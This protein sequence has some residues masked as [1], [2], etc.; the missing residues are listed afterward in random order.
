LSFSPSA[1]AQQ[2]PRAVD[3][4]IMQETLVGTNATEPIVIAADYMAA[5]SETGLNVSLG[6]GNVVVSQGGTAIRAGNAVAWIDR[7]TT[8]SGTVTN[9]VVY[10]EKPIDFEGGGKNGKAYYG[11]IRLATTSGVK[12]NVQ[13]SKLVNS[14]QSNDPIY[15][16]AKANLPADFFM[17]GHGPVNAGARQMPSPPPGAPDPGV[18]RVAASQ[19]PDAAPQPVFPGNVPPANPPVYTSPT[20]PPAVPYQI[21]PA[22]NDPRVSPVPAGPP[23]NS[24]G[25]PILPP[26]PPT[27]G[28]EQ[29]AGTA[30]QMS[31]RPRYSGEMKV[32]YKPLGDGWTAVIVTGGVTMFIT[33]TGDKPGFI[34]IEADRL[35]LWTL[36]NG[37]QLFS[38]M[39]SPGGDMNNAYEIYMSGHVDIRTKSKIETET[40]RADEVYYDLRREVAVARRADLEIQSPKLVYPL[41]MQASEIVKPNAKQYNMDKSKTFASLLPSDP[42]LYFVIENTEV[43]EREYYKR[44]LYGLLP[45]YDKDGQPKIAVDH[46]ITG[47]NMTIWMEGVPFFY[48]P[49]YKGRVEE[50]LGPLQNIS[51]GYNTIFGF[52]LYTTWDMLSLLDLDRVDGLRWRLNIDEQTLRGP[53]LGMELDFNRDKLFD[54]NAKIASSFKIYGIYDTGLDVLGGNR[55]QEIFYPLYPNNP[56]PIVHPI[57]RGW[58]FGKVNIQDLPYGFSVVT[59]FALLSDRNFLE[60]FFM[61]TH[62]NELNQE[63][64]LYVKQQ[65]DNW[66]WSVF[67]QANLRDWYTET[68]WWPRFDGNL[69]GLTFLDDNVISDTRGR[70]GY[71]ELRPTL[72]VPFAYLPTDVKANSFVGNV[73]QTFSVPLNA[74]PFK[75]VPYLTGDLSYYSQ[76]A[77][78]QSTG[79]VYAGGGVRFSMPLSR[80]FP[81]IKSELFNVDGIYHKITFT[82]NYFNA[83]SSLSLNSIPQFERVNDDATD[84]ALRD[85]RPWQPFYLPGT[86]NYLLTSNLF[87]PQYF[88]LRRLLDSN[89]DN[90][91]SI[92]VLQLGIRQRWQTERGFPGSEHVVDFMTLNLG[93]SIFPQADRDNFGHTFGILQYD[94]TWNI[95]DRTAL[96]SSGWFEPFQ[97]GPDSF[98]MGIFINRPDTTNFY[99]GYRQID[100]ID[101]KAVVATVTY[102]LSAKYAMTAS[103]VWD[104]GTH[105][106][107]YSLTLARMGTDVMMAVGLSYNSTINTFG[108]TFEI[109]P[110]LT[111]R[112]G[113]LLGSMF[114]IPT[115]PANAGSITPG[116]Q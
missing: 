55:G 115:L 44:Q 48:F 89:P 57:D 83:W 26:P 60:Q 27:T 67:A 85:I 40:L 2:D 31:I 6:R 105:V 104:F 76:D 13:T 94:W 101:S 87:N 112:P 5:W 8:S 14:D 3:Q 32:E 52:Q 28:K 79:R 22:T 82:G 100:P 20:L 116:R 4:K 92:D 39:K 21:P 99:L 33:K 46:P 69:V 30:L 111:R 96:V 65:Q 36:S 25:V 78:D 35:V 86:A 10:G 72:Q 108:F 81:D 70:L 109:T 38:N 16:Y 63:T 17:L 113:T 50:P 49:Y 11:Y 47:T 41:H 51:L 114:P 42:G 37:Q 97:G 103:T 91:D 106:S 62:L 23:A 18:Q 59:Q 24:Q 29:S 15:Q 84:Q 68:A 95:G 43:Q 58:A 61:N 98:D 34:D 1:Q 90:L 73:N 45:S 80:Y 7:Q 64:Y 110:N 56:N 12:L 102:P 9:V 88:A 53:A 93:V 71:A 107:T 74:G 66:A 77:N 19:P 75:I 54:T